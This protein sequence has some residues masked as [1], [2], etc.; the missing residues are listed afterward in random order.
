MRTICFYLLLGCS[1][2]QAECCSLSFDATGGYRYDEI[3]TETNLFFFPGHSL[4]QVLISTDT[5]RERHLSVFETGF[6]GR[7][8]LNSVFAK[9]FYNHG[10]IVHGQYSEAV[11]AVNGNHSNTQA[12]VHF[13]QTN[14]L[15][16]GIGY[17]YSFLDILKIG[18]SFGWSYDDQRTQMN[19]TMTNGKSD[20]IL[21]D[22]N[23]KLHWQGPWI[24]V[25]SSFCLLCIDLCV[26]Y[27]FHWTAWEGERLLNRKDIF[28]IAFSD[29]R[30]ATGLGNTAY[31]QANYHFFPFLHVGIGA[32]YQ[33]R[34][35]R[36]GTVLPR[37]GDF[38]RV[39]PQKRIKETVPKTS[40][41]SYEIQFNAGIHF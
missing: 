37:V 25:E 33:D 23:Y 29:Q 31:L 13:G 11:N 35:A 17:L 16:A 9:G 24:G 30:K 2:L 40:W 38:E 36:G 3:K 32:K 7:A 21:K 8:S 22:L 6:M 14:D 12:V 18:A 10:W 5:L 34:I 41:H 28:N 26:G 15:S 1:A 39:L 27:E 4:K 20:K 19:H